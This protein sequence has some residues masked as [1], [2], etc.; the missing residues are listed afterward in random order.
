M[1][2]KILDII[3]EIKELNTLDNK[4]IPERIL[5]YDEEFGEFSAELCKLLGLTHKPYDKE[6]STEEM[7]DV[8]QVLFS[9][10]LDICTKTGITMEEV[11][12][13]IP[14]KNNKWR[15]KIPNYTKNKI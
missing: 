4:T 14:I 9:I 2:D 5:K 8:I 12:D 15:E 13:E 11:F 7:A 10:Y 1:K 3:S 6:H